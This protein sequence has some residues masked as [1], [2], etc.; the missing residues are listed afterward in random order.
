MKRF[1]HFVAASLV[2]ASF[3]AMAQ[4]HTV[5]KVAIV[6]KPKS[7]VGACPAE[8]TFVATIFVSHHPVKVRYQWERSDGARATPQDVE[9]TSAARGVETTWNVGAPGKNLHI[10]EKLHVL[11]PTGIRSQLAAV[12]LSCK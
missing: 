2:L 4:E 5:T 9:I 1:R 10:W 3:A 11:A 8:I 12:D 7:Y 6:A